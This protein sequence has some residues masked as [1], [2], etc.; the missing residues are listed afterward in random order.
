MEKFLKINTDYYMNMRYIREIYTGGSSTV[1]LYSTLGTT[2]DKTLSF[3][4]AAEASAVAAAL[5]QAYD[6]RA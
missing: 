2:Y 1:Y 3:S 6:P 4:S 5:A